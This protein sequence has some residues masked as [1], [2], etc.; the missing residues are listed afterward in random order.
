MKMKLKSGRYKFKMEIPVDV[1]HSQ[2]EDGS[3]SIDIVNIPDENKLWD[4]VFAHAKEIKS[5]VALQAEQVG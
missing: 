3:V 2:R 4:M 1:H 5:D